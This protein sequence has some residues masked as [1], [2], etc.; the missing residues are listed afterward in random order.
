[1]KAVVNDS[2]TKGKT[3]GPTA[4]G[5]PQP[6]NWNAAHDGSLPPDWQG[7]FAS[8]TSSGSS[9]PAF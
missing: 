3:D 1:M 2:P 4:H 7:S 8:A 5:S 6:S 9:N